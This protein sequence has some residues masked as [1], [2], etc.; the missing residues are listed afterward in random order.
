MSKRAISR[1]ILEELY[2]RQGLS[3]RDVARRLG[4]AKKT[5]YRELA[6][7][8]I[9]QHT[10]AMI[11]DILRAKVSLRDNIGEG[12]LR[13]MYE[14]EQLS[15]NRIAE[16]L[17]VSPSTITR[18]M[19]ELDIPRRSRPEA[20]KIATADVRVDIPESALRSLYDEG[21][22]ARAIGARF[23]V[24]ENLI[25]RRL[26]EHG[27]ETRSASEASIR[28]PKTDFN[29]NPLEKAY[30]IGFRLGD[31]WVGRQNPDGATISITCSSSKQAQIDLIASLF[32]DYGRVCIGKPNEEGHISVAALVNDSFT[33]L[34]PKKESIEPWIMANGDVTAHRLH[35]E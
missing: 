30:L 16:R 12:T 35:P 6:R 2:V 8:G 34:L 22:S 5:I 26:D 27:I 3:G 10:P 4:C 21:F 7:H 17:S 14:E 31:L 28:Y 19:D 18:R 23:G 25:F 15:V 11:G 1:E 24:S 33:F 32:R 9:P 13:Q 29:G 20:S